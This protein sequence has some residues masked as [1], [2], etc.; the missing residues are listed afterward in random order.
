MALAVVNRYSA[1]YFIHA[2]ASFVLLREEQNM[3]N[4]FYCYSSNFI[5]SFNDFTFNASISRYHTWIFLNDWVWKYQYFDNWKSWSLYGWLQ[6]GDNFLWV[7]KIKTDKLEQNLQSNVQKNHSSN[8]CLLFV[9]DFG[10]DGLLCF[11]SHSL[12]IIVCW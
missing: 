3:E 6:H 8:D 7:Q 2:F 11:Q 10:I 9:H 4:P 1:L 5:S 12:I